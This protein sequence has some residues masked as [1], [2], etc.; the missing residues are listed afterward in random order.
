MVL[1]MVLLL[2]VF[3][4]VLL[5]KVFQMVLLL[6]V[7]QMVLLLKVFQIVVLLQMV[8]QLRRR[9]GGLCGGRVKSTSPTFLFVAV[10]FAWG[11]AS[12]V[13]ARLIWN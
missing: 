5:L 6:K 1:Q 4:M 9:R 11:S 8:F 3:Q 7:F 10:C 13:I 12:K 2:E